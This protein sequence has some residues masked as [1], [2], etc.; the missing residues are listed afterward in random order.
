MEK[1]I[2]RLLAITECTRQLFGEYRAQPIAEGLGAAADASLQ[3]FRFPRVGSVPAKWS[4]WRGRT[5]SVSPS[6][7][8]L[9]AAREATTLQRLDLAMLI[10][11]AAR[12]RRCGTS[13]GLS[14]SAGLTSYASQ[15]PSP[16]FTQRGGERK[17]V[18]DAMPLVV[19]S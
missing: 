16:L 15:R 7:D 5:A 12:R 19:P 2:V 1:G 17:R 10:Q 13:L 4:R 9:K 11:R 6:D 3:Q 8:S 18:A 14:K